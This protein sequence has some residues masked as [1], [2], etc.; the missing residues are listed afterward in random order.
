LPSIL[1]KRMT[2]RRG[3][4]NILLKVSAFGRFNLIL[5]LNLIIHQKMRDA[6]FV[7]RE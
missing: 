4:R 5:E 1:V 2:T 3:V 7:M 6:G